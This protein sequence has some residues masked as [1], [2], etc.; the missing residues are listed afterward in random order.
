MEISLIRHG[1][2]E[3]NEHMPITCQEF[4]NWVEQYDY[5]G[6]VE[7][8]IYPLDSLK[9]IKKLFVGISRQGAFMLL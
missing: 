7:E 9:K 2:S 8:L 6:V 3:W 5:M 4:A 1:K